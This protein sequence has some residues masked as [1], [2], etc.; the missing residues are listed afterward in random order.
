MREDKE[1]GRM[2]T[3]DFKTYEAVFIPEKG[4]KGFWQK[5]TERECRHFLRHFPGAWYPK[6]VDNSGQ[7][8]LEQKGV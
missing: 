3:A 6:P 7:S 4:H 2:K 1:I 8:D 5:G